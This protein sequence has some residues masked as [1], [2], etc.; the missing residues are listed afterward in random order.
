MAMKHLFAV[1]AVIAFLAL[2]SAGCAPKAGVKTPEG[3]TA[4]Y[5]VKIA[6]TIK[7]AQKATHDVGTASESLV[8]K[9]GALAALQGLDKVNLVGL[10]LADELDKIVALRAA[11]QPVSGDAL[12]TIQSYLDAID[13]AIDLDV[14]PH[15]G[16]HPEVTAALEAARAVS[17]LMLEIQL[18]VGQ[19]KGGV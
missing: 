8:I 16:D 13:A 5:G 14:I 1:F 9:K 15:L 6:K 3:Q 10:K 2:P 17:K 4:A 12:A 7:A 19:L 18:Y 11:G